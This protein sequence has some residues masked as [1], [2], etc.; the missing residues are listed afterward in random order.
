V[1]DAFAVAPHADLSVHLVTS[2]RYR[3]GNL[4]HHLAYL[5]VGVIRL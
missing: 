1:K 4:V 2:E 3:I 5:N